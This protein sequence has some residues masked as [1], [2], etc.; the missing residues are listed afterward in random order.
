MHVC[1]WVVTKKGGPK[2]YS[3]PWVVCPDE[4]SGVRFWE[5][6]HDTKAAAIAAATELNDG[7]P[8]E[9]FKRDPGKVGAWIPDG[10]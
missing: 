2:A 3:E 8:P 9:V 6:D 7:E 10:K 4:G 1:G 5:G